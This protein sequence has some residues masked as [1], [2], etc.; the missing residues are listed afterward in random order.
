MQIGVALLRLRQPVHKLAPQLGIQ[1]LQGRCAWKLKNF[2]KNFYYAILFCSYMQQQTHECVLT[3]DLNEKLRHQKPYK[4]LVFQ[5][6]HRLLSKACTRDSA[7][8]KCR[9]L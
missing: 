2:Y 3:L 1:V 5:Q 8:M 7:E 6:D 9:T 4:T